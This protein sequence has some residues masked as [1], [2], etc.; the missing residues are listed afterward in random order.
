MRSR[1]ALVALLLVFASIA[2]GEDEP[3]ATPTPS[4]TATAAATIAPTAAPTT[5]PTAAPRAAPA[6]TPNVVAVSGMTG[7]PWGWNAVKYRG[8][9]GLRV[10][11]SCPAPYQATGSNVYGTDTYSDDSS[12]CLAGVHVGR[13][14]KES[15]G[16]VVIE[17]APAFD[18]RSCKG[19]TRNGV[20]SVGCNTTVKGSYRFV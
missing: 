16:D 15:G 14:T 9:N 4:A 5:A 6:A 17:I 18:Y 8:Q 7:N 3:E 1:L 12:V 10:R 11:Y 13:I 19:T 20:T 2:C